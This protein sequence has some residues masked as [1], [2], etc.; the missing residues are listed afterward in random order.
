MEVLFVSSTASKGKYERIREIRERKILDPSQKFFHLLLKGLAGVKSG[1]LN[2]TCL[3]V[4]PVSSSTSGRKIWYTETETDESGI[5]YKYMGFYNGRIGRYLTLYFA[6]A[7]NTFRWMWQTRKSEER[8][9]VCDPLVFMASKPARLLAS[10]FGVKTVAFITDLPTLTS[11]IKDRK[12]SALRRFWQN[13]YERFSN[14]D[15]RKYD[16]YVLITESLN[17][18]VNNGGKP[19]LVIEGSVDADADMTGSAGVTGKQ[20]GRI[21]MYAGGIYAKFGLPNLIGAFMKLPDPDLRLHIYGDGTYIDDVREA[22]IRD[23]RIRYFGV[24]SL[25]EIVV[26]ESEALLLVNCRPAD[27]VFTRYS[28]PSKTLEYMSSGTA[29]VSSRLE[30]IPDD[31][32]PYLFYFD[33]TSEDGIREKLS[34]ILTMP[35][36]ELIEKGKMARDFV[37]KNKNNRVQGGR[38]AEFIKSLSGSGDPVINER[39]STPLKHKSLLNLFHLVI[40]AV[41]I[42]VSD[43]TLMF[44]TNNDNRFILLKYAT[45]IGLGILLFLVFLVSRKPVAKDMLVAAATLITCVIITMVANR[46]VRLGYFYR[47]G[48][49]FAGALIASYISFDLFALQFSRVITVLASASLIGFGLNILRPGFVR[50]FPVIVNTVGLKFYNLFLTAIPGMYFDNITNMPRNFGL[51]R[52][53]GVFQIFLILALSIQLF[54]F[55]KPHVISSVIYLIALLTTLST[56]GYIAVIV[57]LAGYLMS[58]SRNRIDARNKMVLLFIGFAVLAYLLFFTDVLFSA[59]SGSVFGKLTDLS[60]ETTSA[61]VASVLV[62]LK[63]FLSSPLWGVGLT[64]L[65]VQFPVIGSELMGVV[66][67]SNTNTIL[68]QF[69]V[70]GIVFASVWCAGYFGFCRKLGGKPFETLVV[71]AVLVLLFMSQ[72]VSFSLISNVLIMYGIERYNRVRYNEIGG[73]AA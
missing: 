52:E 45:I 6:A 30:G 14:G 11:S 72:N 69:S 59:G 7:V 55:S 51:F 28:F 71:L 65:D 38:I 49:I 56:A 31:Y 23:E 10:V 36:E 9:I 57:L 39:K 64:D 53:P 67:R 25:D 21:I 47:I 22:E 29:A 62:N 8:S 63:I 18:V 13:A 17:S 46:D 26:K 50:L 19:Y 58:N 32:R 60:R 34:E 54:V 70:Y 24:L 2:L 12:Y 42:I 20:D 44:G 40:V 37:L 43:D 15:L 61:R 48:L 73:V 35:D 41:M 3:T 33:D 4:L 27:D 16:A 5:F 68:T 66:V 1:D